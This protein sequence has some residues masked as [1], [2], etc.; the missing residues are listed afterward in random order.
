MIYATRNQRAEH[1]IEANDQIPYPL[2]V[3]IKC[4]APGKT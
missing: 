2:W 1:E 3:V 4:P